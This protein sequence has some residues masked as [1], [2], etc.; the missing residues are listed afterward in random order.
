MIFWSQGTRLNG[1]TKDDSTSERNDSDLWS[2]TS[3]GISEL[4][5]TVFESM[6]TAD[7]KSFI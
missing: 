5:R 4:V 7:F 1:C 3:R 6:P 2:V